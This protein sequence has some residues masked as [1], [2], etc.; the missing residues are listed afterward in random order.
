MTFAEA[1]SQVAVTSATWRRLTVGQIAGLLTATLTGRFNLDHQAILLQTNRADFDRLFC[2]L[3]R[4]TVDQLEIHVELDFSADTQAFARLRLLHRA[5]QTGRSVGQL[6]VLGRVIFEGDRGGDLSVLLFDQIHHV[7]RVGL[8]QR[9]AGAFDQLGELPVGL[10][11]RTSNRKYD[12]HLMLPHDLAELGDRR[13]V[14]IVAFV[15]I[16]VVV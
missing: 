3:R 10:Q 16:A 9:C 4:W 15:V 12:V 11:L 2:A 14:L 13:I 8:E 5:T 1:T 7:R 6:E